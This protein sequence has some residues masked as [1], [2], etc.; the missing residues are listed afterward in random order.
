MIF[1]L[2]EIGT[3]QSDININFQCD[4]NIQIAPDLQFLTSIP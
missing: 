2:L 4:V 3:E 1:R